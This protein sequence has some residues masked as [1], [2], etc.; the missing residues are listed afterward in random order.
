MPSTCSSSTGG[1]YGARRSKIRNAMLAKLLHR[2]PARLQIN[3]HIEE[4]GDVVFRHP[5]SS[6]SRA[7]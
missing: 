7:L 2:A 1:I 4:A 6:D 5:A 3:E